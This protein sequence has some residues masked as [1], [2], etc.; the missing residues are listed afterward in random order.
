HELQESYLGKLEEQSQGKPIR[1]SEWKVSPKEGKQ[2]L[3]IN[4]IGMLSFLYKYADFAWIGG[5][6]GSGIHNTM[7]AAA[8]GIPIGFG[9]NYKRFKEA[10]DLIAGGAAFSE[11]EQKGLINQLNQFVNNEEN[12]KAAGQIA[13][14]YIETHKG[15]TKTIIDYCKQKI[16]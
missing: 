12:R 13:A 6:F 9:P 1:Y 7:E 4:N 8:F 16:R 11:T 14:N 15:A 5:G 3:I 2:V 10:V